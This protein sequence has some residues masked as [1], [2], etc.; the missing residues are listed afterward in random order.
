LRRALELKPDSANVLNALGCEYMEEGR[1]EEAAK[2]FQSAI[3][4]K[5]RWTDSHFNY[6]RLLKKTGQSDAALAEFRTA[7]EVAPMNSTARFYLAQELEERGEDSKAEAQYRM[8]IQLSPSLMA[9]RNLVDILLRTQREDEALMM[10][11]QI[12][13]EYPYDSTTH[14][15]LGRL[16][17][18]EGKSA[19][20]GKEYQAT[21]V[22]DPANAEAQAALKRL[23]SPG[24]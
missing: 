11:Q 8:S 3:A 20:A 16:L 15:K 9:R 6:G 14:V 10:L 17:E 24:K 2:T 21:L 1:P 13:K 12:A 5:P 19:E 23:K 7:V 22:T 18:K 4:S